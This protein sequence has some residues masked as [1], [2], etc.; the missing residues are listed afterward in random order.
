MTKN[1]P[2][3]MSS[4]GKIV[5]AL[6]EL[7]QEHD[8]GDITITEIVQHAKVSRMAF[9]RNFLSKTDVLE[10]FMR[11]LGQGIDRLL[12]QYRVPP[13][14]EQYFAMLFDLLGRYSSQIQCACR[15][16]LADM[17]RKNIDYS[18]QNNF[19]T[20]KDDENAYRCSVMA[21]A[22]FNV[23]LHWIESGKKETP[24]QMAALCSRM[25]VQA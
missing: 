1:E 25:L 16:N 23:Y 15:A 21:G 19:L 10:H 4:R 8:F 13:D 17:L 7:M 2:G 24:Q 5:D 6:V 20:N 3:G 11:N 14:L 12:K 9:Y 18:V 22:F